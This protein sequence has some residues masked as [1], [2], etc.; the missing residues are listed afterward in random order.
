MSI[1]EEL[2]LDFAQECKTIQFRYE[3]GREYV[4]EEKFAIITN[5][6]EAELREKYAD[7]LK[8]YEPFVVLPLEY[9]EIRDAYIRNDHTYQA[10]F[11]RGDCVSLDA[12]LEGWCRECAAEDCAE[13]AMRR[14][15]GEMLAELVEHLPEIQRRRI[16]GRFYEGKT[17]R[18]MAQEESVGYVKIYNSILCG[19]ANIREKLLSGGTKDPSQCK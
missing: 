16:K 4:G 12:G 8:R 6:T 3:Y 18:E 2:A 14:M 5:L 1:F 15:E 11:S 9:G 10:R 17:L 13:Q 19:M 7:L